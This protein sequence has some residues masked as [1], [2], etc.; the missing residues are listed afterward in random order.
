MAQLDPVLLY[1]GTCGFCAESVQLVLKHDRTGALRFAALDS[2]YGRRVLEQHPGIEHIDSMIWVDTA[3]DRVYTRAA[4]VLRVAA[5]LGGV[6]RLALIA[7]L[8]PRL[9]RDA[10]YRFVAKHR[11][12]LTRGGTQCV[13]PSPDQRARFL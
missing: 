10:V 8:V 11:H 12:Q 6:W 5:Y 9:L 3:A 4:A 7:W 1:D 2:A 13:V